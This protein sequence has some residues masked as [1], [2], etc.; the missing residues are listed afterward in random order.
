MLVDTVIP[1]D[2][3]TTPESRNDYSTPE[4]TATIALLAL[5]GLGTV[6][7]ST[8]AEPTDNGTEQSSAPEEVEGSPEPVDLTGEWTQSNANDSGSFQSATITADTIEVYWNAPDTKSL[9][10]AGTI[11][12]PADGSSSFTWDSANDKTK[13]DTA[14]MASG[15]DTK[16]FTYENGELAYDVTAMGTT[17]TVRLAKE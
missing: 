2:K 11:E 16:T 5:I 3:C 12:V 8:P 13:T 17:V 9:Y 1:I 14:I 10:W 4:G 7:C 15:D 6:A